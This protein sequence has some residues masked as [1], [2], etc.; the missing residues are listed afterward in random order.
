MSELQLRGVDPAQLEAIKTK[1]IE[2]ARGLFENHLVISTFG[3]VSI[4]IPGTD[5]VLITPSGF[6][7]NTLRNDHLIIVD[8]EAK[9]VAGKYRPSVETTMHT[10][11]HK[12]RPE[13]TTIIHTHSPMAVAFAA[14]NVEIPCVS[15]EQAFYLGGRVPI[16]RK[17]SY[18]GTTEPSELK[19]ILKTLEKTNAALL[20]K[21]G[22]IVV[23]RTPEDALDTAIVLEDVAKVAFHSIQLAKPREF[24]KTEINYLKEFK[25]TKYGQNPEPK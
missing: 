19:A 20:R 4:R 24:T 8:L 23:G 7:K 5:N 18:P 13:L 14:A 25:R 1:V 2:V 9:L 10:Y 6:S 12:H 17:Y 22:V 16:V 3:V 15:A 11:V 21:H